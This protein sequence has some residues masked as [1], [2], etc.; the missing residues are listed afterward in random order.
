[1]DEEFVRREAPGL[2]Y[3]WLPTHDNGGAQD[4]RWFEHGVAGIL[5]ILDDPDA[6]V[7][8]HCHMGVNRAPSLA[9]A[10]LLGLGFDPIAALDAIRTARPIAGILYAADAV[11]WWADRDGLMPA[12]IARDLVEAWHDANPVDLRWIISR[13]RKAEVSDFDGLPEVA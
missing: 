7:V 6:R 11:E 13:I 1:S 2:T 5:A 10:A 3:V 8:V 12:D 4:P 9:F